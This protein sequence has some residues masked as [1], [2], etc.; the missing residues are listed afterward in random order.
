VAIAP[1]LN[2]RAELPDFRRFLQTEL[3]RRCNGNPQYSLRAFAKSLGVDHSTLSQLLRGKRRFTS[4]TIE[5]LAGRLGVG[6][7]QAAAFIEFERRNDGNNPAVT[8]EA[9]VQLAH[10][11]VS[12]ISEWYPFAILELVRLQEFTPD[13]RWIARVLGIAPDEVNVALH[14]LLRMGLLEM[15]ERGRWRTNVGE[16][17]P[18][19]ESFHLATISR[20]SEQVQKLAS[21]VAECN[22]MALKTRGGA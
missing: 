7:D 11:A 21:A 3:A 10:D 9:I 6:G 20:L 12:L 19:V 2:L 5:K 14:R 22:R 18:T 16:A 1:I 17:G 4:A 15:S 13:T 8:H